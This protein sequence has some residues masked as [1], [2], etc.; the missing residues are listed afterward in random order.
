ME[1]NLSWVFNNIQPDR[2]GRGWRGFYASSILVMS[3]SD[4]NVIFPERNKLQEE[5]DKKLN[6]LLND[7]TYL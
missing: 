4:F 3:E 5:R 7:Y 1:S 6:E 2:N